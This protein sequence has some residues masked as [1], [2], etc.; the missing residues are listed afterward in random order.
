MAAVSETGE[1]VQARMRAGSSRKG[2]A[3]FIVEV[4]NRTRR[5][6]ATGAVTVRA[7]SQVLA[8]GS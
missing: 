8:L 1:I 5:A 6:G 3:H 4:V 2:H 7:D